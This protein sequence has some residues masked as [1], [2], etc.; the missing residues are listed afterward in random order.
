MRSARSTPTD[1][2]TH[3][4]QCRLVGR[5]RP[6]ARGRG[7]WPA[8]PSPPTG[9][10]TVATR[11]LHIADRLQ[12]IGP[13][14][15]RPLVRHPVDDVGD[16][17][18]LDRC[19]ISG[20]GVDAGVEQ[21]D[22]PAR[23]GR[24]GPPPCRQIGGT[25]ARLPGPCVSGCFT[26][27]GGAF[28]PRR[29]PPFAV[30]EVVE[31]VGQ[32]HVDVSGPLGE[33]SEQLVRHAGDLGLTVHDRT[34]IDTETV[35]EL[36]PQHGLVEAA[37]HPLMPLQVAGIQRQPTAITRSGPWPRS[38]HGC[39]SVDHRPAMSSGGTSPSSTHSCPGAAGR[40]STRMRVVDPNRSKWSS[41]AVTATSCAS[42]SRRSPVS[43][44]HTDNDFGAENV[45]SNPDTARTTRPSAAYRS[46]NSR[47]NGVPVIGSRPD[48]NNSNASTST[49]PDRPSPSA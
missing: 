44:H 9:D 35:G 7:R 32:R 22:R 11:A 45:A 49:R 25:V 18:R 36:G 1:H 6:A 17:Q 40:R 4:G 47:P 10:P 30:A 3:A 20:G 16:Q 39:G 37:E 23:V 38:P 28:P 33:H 46:S 29:L 48:N 34:P 43:A 42:R 5:D 14:P 21:V 19:G 26:G 27:Q 41:A 2:P 13:S 15:R 24:F 12:H 8:P 31:L